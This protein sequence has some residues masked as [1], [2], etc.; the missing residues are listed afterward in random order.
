[1]N[2]IW[3]LIYNPASGLDILTAVDIVVTLLHWSFWTFLQ[4]LIQWTTVS[5]WNDCSGRFELLAVHI[6]G[7]LPIYMTVISVFDVV[8]L[9]HPLLCRGVAFHKALFRA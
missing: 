1:M 4:P 6:N 9:H 8:V 2:I 3:F 5:Y 7:C